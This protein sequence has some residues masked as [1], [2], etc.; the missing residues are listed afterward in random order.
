MNFDLSEEQLAMFE[1]AQRFGAE[2]IAP[3]AQDW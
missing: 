3:F 2:H 1:M